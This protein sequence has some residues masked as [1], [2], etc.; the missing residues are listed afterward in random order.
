[1][2]HARPFS[3]NT[4]NCSFFGLSRTLSVPL[5]HRVPRPLAAVLHVLDFGETGTR[6][7]E[8][9]GSYSLVSLIFSLLEVPRIV[10]SHLQQAMK[11]GQRCLSGVR[12]GTARL[13]MI[14]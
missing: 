9:L 12:V 7:A 13:T 5:V 6:N 3:P 1:M 11:S 8:E 10:L 2:L 14:P 4:I